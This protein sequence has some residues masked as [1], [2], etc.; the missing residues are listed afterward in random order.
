[1]HQAEVASGYTAIVPFRSGKSSARSRDVIFLFLFFS[2]IV[3]DLDKKNVAPPH[4]LD[5]TVYTADLPLS[6]NCTDL[7]FY[8]DQ[9]QF[10]SL[11]TQLRLCRPTHL[12]CRVPTHLRL[13]KPIL[14]TLQTHFTF[15]DPLSCIIDPPKSVHTHFS[16]RQTLLEMYRP[17]YL[18]YRPT[19]G[20]A[21][22]FCLHCRLTFEFKHTIVYTADPL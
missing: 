16:S 3:F 9:T 2:K 4:V 15:T 13:F 12:H 19:L 18:R 6:F 1:M 5:P 14:Y 10:S 11:Q 22:P 7:L 21:D 8:L 17:T 20:F